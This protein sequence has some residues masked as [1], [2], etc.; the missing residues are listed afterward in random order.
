M[1]PVL[2]PLRWLPVHFS[3]HLK[4]AFICFYLFVC[5]CP[6]S[7]YLPELL[8]PYTPSHSLRWAIRL[9]LS[10]PRTRQELRRDRA[11]VLVAPTL[12]N[13]LPL[14]HQ[15]SILFLFVFKSFL[16]THLFTLAF[17]TAWHVGIFYYF[18]C[19]H[20]NVLYM[21]F[22]VYF[23]LLFWHTCSTLVKRCCK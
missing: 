23:W 11:F 4:I 17:G 10:V 1:T 8:R 3:I 14:I 5:C 21:W 9:L 22:V 13:E 16:K 7:M 6:Y 15:T 2:F 19:L 20:F 12:W 18:I